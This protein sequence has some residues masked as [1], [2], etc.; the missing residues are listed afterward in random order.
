MS[1]LCKRELI[2]ALGELAADLNRRR[3]LHVDVD[4]RD[5]AR[6]SAATPS[7]TS[8]I[9]R[10]VRE[11]W[12][13]RREAQLPTKRHVV[14]YFCSRRQHGLAGNLGAIFADASDE[15]R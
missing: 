11:Q 2:L 13:N 7:I 9:V 3:I 8:L 10:M 6:I 4:A 14:R 15:E 1:G 5:R 12:R